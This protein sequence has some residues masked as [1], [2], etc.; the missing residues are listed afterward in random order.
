MDRKVLPAELQLPPTWLQHEAVPISCHGVA[1]CQ[2]WLLGVSS[3]QFHPKH[4]FWEEV[5][6]LALAL[7]ATGRRMSA[8]LF[9]DRDREL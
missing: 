1:V 6:R 2:Y 4:D 8:L 7:S 9:Q 5:H 3:V